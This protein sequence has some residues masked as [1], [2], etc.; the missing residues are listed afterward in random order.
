MTQKT[1]GAADMPVDL[2]PKIEATRASLLKAIVSGDKTAD[3]RQYLREL[4]A[5]QAKIDRAAA[6][7]QAAQDAAQAAAAEAQRQRIADAAASLLEARNARIACIATRFPIP[8]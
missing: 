8:A 7:E 1:K 2:K 4:E 5:E 3:L 6:D